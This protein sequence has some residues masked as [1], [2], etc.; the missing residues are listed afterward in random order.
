MIAKNTA[1]QKREIVDKFFDTVESIP[2]SDREEAQIFLSYYEY[3]VVLEYL[4]IKKPWWFQK[5]PK[6]GGIT[7]IEE[8]CWC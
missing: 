8:R 2:R 1:K 5:W 4:Q 6:Y 7:L 3:R